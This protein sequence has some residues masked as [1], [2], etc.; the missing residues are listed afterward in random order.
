[1]RTEKELLQKL[2]EIRQLKVQ[3][4]RADPFKEGVEAFKSPYWSLCRK[5]RA[6]LEEL[7]TEHRF[8]EPCTM[9]SEE[10]GNQVVDKFTTPI[11]DLVSGRST[12]GK[13]DYVRVASKDGSTKIFYRNGTL[14]T[15]KSSS[16]PASPQNPTSTII[17][18]SSWTE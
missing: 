15:I 11:A 4:P 18:E 1:M 9:F 14:E 12:D 7:W 17:E 16:D 3:A 5:E 8:R 2:A 6:I 13:L 10:W